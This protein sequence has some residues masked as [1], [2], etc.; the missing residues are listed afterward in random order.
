MPTW[1][2]SPVPQATGLPVSSRS[3]ALHQLD[4]GYQ[5]RRAI[6]SRRRRRIGLQYFRLLTGEYYTLLDFVDRELAG[7]SLT[8]DWTFPFPHTIVNVTTATPTRIETGF[9]H[10]YQTSDWVTVAGVGAGIDGVRQVTWVSATEIDLDGTSGGGTNG[11]VGMHFPTMYLEMPA[12]GAELS[13]AQPTRLP[14]Y[15]PRDN[16]GYY[17]LGYTLVE[18]F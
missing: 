11:F 13:T 18:A 2:S 5:T 6:V 17:Q 3:V 4:G 8:F 7:G 12:R 9:P 14:G 16:E 1:P 15:Q 10:G